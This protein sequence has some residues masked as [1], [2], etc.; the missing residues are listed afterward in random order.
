M[1]RLAGVRSLTTWSPKLMVPL[2]GKLET[3]QHAERRRLAAA[4][5]PEQAHELAGSDF[6][7]KIVHCDERAELLANLLSVMPMPRCM[8][9]SP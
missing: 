7:I 4:R 2:V 9:I 5:R 6:E 8:P 3:G 1:L